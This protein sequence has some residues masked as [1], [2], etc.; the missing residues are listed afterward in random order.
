LAI[1]VV[2]E[3]FSFTNFVVSCLIFDVCN[4]DPSL[5]LATYVVPKAF[6]FVDP[7]VSNVLSFTI[8]IVDPTFSLAI[9]IIS[10]AFYFVSSTIEATFF[11][12]SLT[13]S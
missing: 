1:V 7:C 10:E 4:V 13:F 5:S 6:S 2:L 8:S 3:A 9:P 11:F 12:V